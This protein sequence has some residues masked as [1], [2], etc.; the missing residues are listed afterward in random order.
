[1]LISLLI[2]LAACG[3]AQLPENAEITV[4]N[5]H[6]GTQHEYE[7]LEEHVSAILHNSTARHELDDAIHAEEKEDL[8]QTLDDEEEALVT[9][10]ID[11]VADVYGYAYTFQALQEEKGHL[12]H[13]EH[14]EK[15]EFSV[16]K[17]TDHPEPQLIR[18]D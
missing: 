9:R 5:E 16:D 6:V 15:T 11:D 7:E 18:H 10:E 12:Y 1:M 17:F 3:I 8:N 14:P 4:I 2:A 13:L